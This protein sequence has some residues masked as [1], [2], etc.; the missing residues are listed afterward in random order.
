MDLT[1]GNAGR[2]GPGRGCGAGVEPRLGAGG[3]GGPRTGPA[4]CGNPARGPPPRTHPPSRCCPL[5]SPRELLRALGAVGPGE[6]R[7]GPRTAGHAPGSVGPRG[8]VLLLSRSW[9]SRI[10]GRPEGGGSPGVVIEVAGGCLWEERPHPAFPGPPAAAGAARSSP[11]AWVC[12]LPA[13]PGTRGFGDSLLKARAAI[14]APCL[15]HAAVPSRLP[16]PGRPRGWS[17]RRPPA[18]PPQV[19][20]LPSA[21]AVGLFTPSELRQAPGYF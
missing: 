6:P 1:R 14:A 21:A 4:G 19:H 7:A 18:A 11:P 12:S 13:A 20:C 16:F 9:C 2:R 8:G 15:I 10:L 17:W 3:R 5:P